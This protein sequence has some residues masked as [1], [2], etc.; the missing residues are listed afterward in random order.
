MSHQQGETSGEAV[1]CG[2]AMLCRGRQRKAEHDL[3]EV[4]G[5]GWNRTSNKGV[6]DLSLAAWV[7]RHPWLTAHVN[8]GL[9]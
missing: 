3:L 9:S 5:A 4:G 8:T 2:E 1:R 6:A 7:P